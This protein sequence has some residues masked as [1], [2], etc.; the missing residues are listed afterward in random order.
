M[1]LALSRQMFESC[2]ASTFVYIDTKSNHASTSNLCRDLT[3]QGK[4]K[5]I[6][7]EP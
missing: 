4:W 7:E 1:D 5:I 3:C 6:K 2:H